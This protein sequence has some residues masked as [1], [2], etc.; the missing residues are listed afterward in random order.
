MRTARVALTVA[1]LGIAYCSTDYEIP[2]PNRYFIARW[3]PSEFALIA[4]D[5]HTVVIQRVSRYRVDGNIISGEEASVAGAEPN[6]FIVDTNAKSVETN[7]SGSDWERRLESLG[8]QNH[9][10]TKPKR[11]KRSIF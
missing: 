7:L 1:L 6:Y 9:M 5:R 2:L 8:I 3:Q 10:L 4:P 11:P